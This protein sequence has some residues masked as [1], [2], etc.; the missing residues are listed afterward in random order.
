[1]TDQ[2]QDETAMKE[3]MAG[4]QSS[5]V[6]RRVLRADYSR[7]NSRRTG[8]R[9]VRRVTAMVFVVT[10][11]FVICWTPYHVMHF[12]GVYNYQRVTSFITQQRNTTAA[13]SG[14]IASLFMSIYLFKSLIRQN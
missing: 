7:S 6:K 10:L 4:S 13:A 3:P 5:T 14:L 11:V 12:V 1:M 9:P 8:V 2:L